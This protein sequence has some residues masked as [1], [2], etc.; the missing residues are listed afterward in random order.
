[1]TRFLIGLVLGL[2]LGVYLTDRANASAVLHQR[3]AS[4]K[5]S[6]PDGPTSLGTSLEDI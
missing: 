2:I 3:Y 5:A 4:I 1:M 6:E